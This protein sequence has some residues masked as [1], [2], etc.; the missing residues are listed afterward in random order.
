[1]FVFKLNVLLLLVSLTNSQNNTSSHVQ[2][3]GRHFRVVAF[4][5]EYLS[6]INFDSNTSTYTYEGL[7]FDIFKQISK[8]YNL[9]MD[10]YT[11]SQQEWGVLLSNGSWT[12]A[13]EELVAGEIHY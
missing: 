9:I 7:C 4:Q 13:I 2:D 3:S 8:K 1:M 10:V 6:I 11:L 5:Y 12:G